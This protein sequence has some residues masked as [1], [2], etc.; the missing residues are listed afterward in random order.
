MFCKNCGKEIENN[1]KFCS[2]CGAS[3]ISE[4][5]KISVISEQKTQNDFD[6]HKWIMESAP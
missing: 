2:E 3:Q 4:E 5:Q 1:V 6:F